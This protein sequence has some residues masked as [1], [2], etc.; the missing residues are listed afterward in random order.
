MQVVNVEV[1]DWAAIVIILIKSWKIN[2]LADF[3]RSTQ[4][5]GERKEKDI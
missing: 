4:K 5:T 3:K 2:M 1:T